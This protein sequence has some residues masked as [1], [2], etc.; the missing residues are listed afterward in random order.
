MIKF[1]RSIR[2]TLLS[3]GKTKSY[4]KYA[5]GEIILVV[6]GI[7]IALSINTLNANKKSRKD[8]ALVISK[9]K[10]E[11]FSNRKTLSDARAINQNI[12]N[13]YNDFTTVYNDNSSEVVT[14]PKKMEQLQKTYP[15]FFRIKDS[16]KLDDQN[17]KYIGGTVIELEIP[18]LTSIAWETTRSIN[19][20]NEFDYG[21]L[22]DLENM[23]SLQA[24][25]QRE[26]DKAVE[27]LQKE[28]IN[29]LFKVLGVMNQ[30]DLQLKEDYDEMLQNIDN[31]K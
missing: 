4:L 31:C 21:C 30:L 15:E 22:Y 20:A 13:A 12:L 14:T 27:A 17:Y 16:L 6:I 2:K 3:E 24:R 8:K 26:I 1:F 23:Y 29:T 25:A 7:L 28:D 5:I 10:N 18:N 11:I 9:I 19:I